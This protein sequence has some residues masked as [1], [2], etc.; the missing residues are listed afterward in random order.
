MTF[1]FSSTPSREGT[2]SR[3]MDQ[4]PIPGA[5]VRPGFSPIPMW[6]ADMSFP[7]APAIPQAIAR[8]L[9]HP[10]FG[11]FTPPPEYYQ[12][13]LRWHRTRNGAQG[14][15]REHI[16]YENGVIGGVVSALDA[17]C[18]RGDRV[19]LHSPTYT[20]FTNAL[21]NCG[22]R[23]VHSP[24]VQDEEGVWRMDWDDMEDKLRRFQFRAALFCSPHNPCGRVWEGWEVERAMELYR[25]Y[26]VMVVSDEIWSD[27]VLPGYRHIPTQ[28]VSPDA[29][30][31]TVALYSPTKS[32]NLAG[33]VGAYHIIYHPQ[34]RRQVERVGSLT[35]Y[36]SMNLLSV[37]ALIGAYSPQGEAW[38]DQLRQVLADNV[39]LA[40]GYIRDHFPGVTLFR[41]Q[42]TYM[43]FL[44]CRQWCA[45]HG[46]TLDQLLRAG[47]E[48]GVIWQDGR[49]FFGPHHIRMNLA[50][51]KSTL[52]QAL[53]RLDRYVFSPVPSPA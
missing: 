24:L 40:C 14:L 34:L 11:Y 39:D 7:T 27:L 30:Q 44:D 47:V 29:R 1:D 33:L 42:G 21:E 28:S 53:E 38:L 46:R 50:L 16:G 31:R 20:G 26:D 9:E 25:K 8:R 17:L 22:Y 45:R 12:A 18:A 48:V 51:P 10:L 41:P 2:G 32:F 3:A 49:P 36:N 19:L 5:R 13:I 35:H 4:I 52:V 6:I 23:I 37:H 43:L 15:E